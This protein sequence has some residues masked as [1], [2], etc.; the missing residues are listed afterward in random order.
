MT[1]TRAEPNG[2]TTP[3]AALRKTNNRG[4]LGASAESITRARGLCREH[5][6]ESRVCVAGAAR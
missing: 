2:E 1:L 4:R 6:P 5:N 3:D